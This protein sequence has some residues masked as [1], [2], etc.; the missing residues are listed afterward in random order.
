MRTSAIS[1]G[2][3]STT[4][5]T[6]IDVYEVSPRD[7]L[8]NEAAILTVDQKMEVIEKLAEARPATVEVC[9]YVREDRVPQM[10]GA[11]ELCQRINQS[12]WAKAARDDGTQ[13]SALILNKKGFERFM[14]NPL[15]TVTLVVSCTNG[16]SKVRL[17][18]PD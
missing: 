9:S 18:S 7:G 10:A 5:A 12:A 16:H 15:D 8:Q 14:L 4:A 2:A 3:Y 1:S 17:A 6:E 11:E 13:F